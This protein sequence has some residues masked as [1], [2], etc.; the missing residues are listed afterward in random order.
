M[1]V[2]P[3]PA[4]AAHAAVHAARE[5]AVPDLVCA[6]PALAIVGFAAAGLCQQ[7]VGRLLG[8]TCMYLAASRYGTLTS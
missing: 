3:L 2:A 8:S 4:P 5:A 1:A 7:W 6:A